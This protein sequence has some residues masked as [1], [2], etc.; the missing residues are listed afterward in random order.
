[1]KLSKT[2]RIGA[3]ALLLA[4]I[5][6]FLVLRPAPLPVDSDVV[7]KGPLQVL[8][9]GEGVTRV[10]ER[11]VIS[12][13][14]TGSIERITLE[15]GDS[16]RKGTPVASVLPAA[17]DARDF[18]E[19]SLRAGSGRA[20]YDE[21]VSRERSVTLNLEQANRRAERFK[22]LYRE[23]AISRESFE[24][25]E[26]EAGVLRR[27]ADAARSGAAAARYNFEALESRVDS[28]LSSKS[29]T[30]FSPADGKVLRV[31]EKSQR[32][33]AAGAPLLDLGDPSA[34]EI[35]IDVLSSDAVGVR[36]GCRVIVSDWGGQSD[37]EAVV[38]KIEPAAFTKTSALGIEEKRVNIIAGLK[39]Y[40]PRLGDNFRVQAKI[41]LDEK[42]NVVQVPVSSLFRGKTSWE[43]FVLENGRAV[44]RHV[45]IGMRGIWRAEVVKGLMPGDRVVVHP[46][47]ELQDGMRVKT[48]E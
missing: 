16:V 14:V 34:I 35:V 1:M 39:K 18:R 6:L 21:A 30:V 10:S 3:I 45:D 19:A 29:V 4:C 17:L 23:G 25:A 36:P 42:Q 32:V 9:E 22:N 24:I 2:Q 41:V 40:E 31:H 20:A 38:M 13:P 8:L 5:V 47:N 43:V 48:K 7:I 37:A 11:Y 27:E 33:V 15:E 26:K 12:S 44:L 28:R 46:T